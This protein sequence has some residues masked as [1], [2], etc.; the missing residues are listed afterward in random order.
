MDMNEVAEDG[1]IFGIQGRWTYGCFWAVGTVIFALVKRHI[2][3]GACRVTSLADEGL[4]TRFHI[5][6]IVRNQKKLDGCLVWVLE[7]DLQ[8]AHLRNAITAA[9]RFFW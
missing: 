2:D 5:G 9:G 7:D 3:D 6:Q 1:A 8:L 4:L